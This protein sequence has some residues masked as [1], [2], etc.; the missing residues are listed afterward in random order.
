MEVVFINVLIL[1][2]LM[3]IGFFMGKKKIVSYKTINDLSSILIDISIPALVI[4]SML[5]PYDQALMDDTIE[6]IIVVIVYHLSVTLLSLGLTKILK[7]DPKKRGSW[8]FGMVFSNNGFMGYPLMY[9]LYGP[10]GLFIMAMA[11]AMQNALVFSIGIKIVNI[12]YNKGASTRIRDIIFTKQNIA[13]TIGMIIFVG[14]LTVPKPIVTMLTYVANITVPLS[15]MV[16]GLSLSRNNFRV[17]F[18]DFEVYRFSI[19][20]MLIVPAIL[21]IVF[22]LIGVDISHNLPMAIL[23]Y[24]AALPAPAF[25]S[26]LAERYNTS[27]EFASKCVSLTTIICVLTIPLFAGLI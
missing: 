18:N 8:V 22:K 2:M 25:T 5:R 24:T 15:M 1:F 12:N 4:V 20:R 10:N 27:M 21:V 9:A 23:F 6:V 26:I 16:V 14:Q 13:L 3:S 11:N 7:V 19:I 17:M